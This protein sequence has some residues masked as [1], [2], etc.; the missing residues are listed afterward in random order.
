[1][2]EGGAEESRDQASPRG[3]SA[4]GDLAQLLVENPW[5]N[6]AL[7]LAFG[8]RERASEAG[9]SVI[10]NLNLPSTQDVDRLARRLRGLSERLEEVEDSLDRHSREVAELRSER[11]S[12]RRQASS[13][14]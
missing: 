11:D 10:R 5:M 12:S 13:Q 14:G 8:V 3:E 6:Q 7:H 4:L 1:M 2:D 9:A